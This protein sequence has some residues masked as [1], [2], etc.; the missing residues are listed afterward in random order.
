MPSPLGA[1]QK[2]CFVFFQ[3]ANRGQFIQVRYVIA[4]SVKK[5]GKCT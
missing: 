5:I 3:G 2:F 1:M 4:N